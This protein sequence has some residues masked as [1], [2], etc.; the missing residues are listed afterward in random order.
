MGETYWSGTTSGQQ[1]SDH[2]WTFQKSMGQTKLDAKTDITAWNDM[3]LG[4]TIRGFL[5]TLAWTK[6]E[7]WRQTSESERRDCSISISRAILFSLDTFLRALQRLAVLATELVSKTCRRWIYRQC[8]ADLTLHYSPFTFWLHCVTTP[9][10][11]LDSNSKTELTEG[12]NSIHISSTLFVPNRASQTWYKGTL[13]NP[14]AFAFD[15]EWWHRCLCQDSTLPQ[16][17]SVGYVGVMSLHSVSPGYSLVLCSLCVS[18]SFDANFLWYCYS[19]GNY[20]TSIQNKDKTQFLSLTLWDNPYFDPWLLPWKLTQNLKI[21]YQ[22]N[23]LG[24]SSSLLH[25]LDSTWGKLNN[26]WFVLG[27]K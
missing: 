2:F 6:L 14:F 8:N 15:Q 12:F 16:T 13:K 17:V 3:I 24:I 10:I 18:A 7:F 20:T 23:I 26:P 1:I 11:P 22:A 9:L 19:T 25:F 21:I 27:C 4:A 5:R